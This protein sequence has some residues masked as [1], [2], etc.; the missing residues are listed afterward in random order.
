MRH[1][2]HEC[3][4]AYNL[5]SGTDWEHKDVKTIAITSARDPALAPLFNYAS[6]AHNNH[7]FFDKILPASTSS[8]SP[9]VAAS[10]LATD[11]NSQIELDDI[12]PASR[13]Q[14]PAEPS[15]LS[16]SQHP[17]ASTAMPNTLRLALDASFS[18]IDTLRREFVATAMAMFGPGFVWLVKANNIPSE[19]DAFR[20]L[21]TYLAGSPYPG[22]H[23]RRQ[24]VDMNTVGVKGSRESMDAVDAYY[25]QQAR[26][27]RR[28]GSGA[29]GA[30]SPPPSAPGGVDVIPVLCLNTWEHVWLTDYGVG[31]KRE[32]IENWWQRIHWEKVA[33]A[34]KIKGRGF[35]S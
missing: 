19:P 25:A 26:E 18:S 21:P 4:L 30:N 5:S 28:P 34:A 15:R 29:I 11:Q 3:A 27:L 9:S 8:S 35:V 17:T 32:Y 2:V 16:S 13:V 20:L 23:A 6:M 33:E 31:G 14:S 22:A 1:W 10:A 24:S 12:N 7:F